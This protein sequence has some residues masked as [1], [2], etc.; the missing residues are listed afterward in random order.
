MND[1]IP[2][3]PRHL[4][5]LPKWNEYISSDIGSGLIVFL[6]ALPLCLGIALASGAPVIAGIITGIVGGT[7]TCLI[8]GSA[9]SVSG[10]A[11]GLTVIILDGIHSLGSFEKFLAAVVIAGIFQIIFAILRLGF[12]AEYIP[13]SVL[14][15]MLAGVGAVIII[16]QIPYT[17]G[18]EHVNVDNLSFSGIL[19]EGS[20]FAE[21]LSAIY[22]FNPTVTAISI[23]S[24]A[25]IYAWESII[26]RSKLMKLI[27]GALIATVVGITL[28]YIIQSFKPYGLSLSQQ[29]LVSIPIFSSLNSLVTSLTMPDFQVLFNHEVIYLGLVM[30]LVAS[31]ETLLSVEAIDRIDPYHRISPT[32]RELLAQGTGNV[33]SGMLGGLPMTAV[34]L[35]SSANVYSGGKTRLA[36]IV[37]GLLLLASLL[38]FSSLLNMIPLSTLAVILILV[39]YKLTQ[40]KE[41]KK[42]YSSGYDQFVPFLVTFIGV[43]ATDLLTGVIMGLIVGLAYVMRTNHH[44]SMTLVSEN[45]NFYLRFNKDVSF[46]NKAELKSNLCCIPD[47]ANVF[48]DGSKSLFI[49]KDIVDLI[50]DFTIQASHRGIELKLK[51]CEHKSLSTKPPTKKSIS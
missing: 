20:S 23:I 14:K 36:C 18:N 34:I 49:D 5:H 46:L 22:Y 29:H 6:V 19:P 43:I 21:V 17:L 13:G 50:N 33:I 48:I 2:T 26:P 7:I 38:C 12:I 4:K 39:G 30:A 28:S 25:L 3:S 16:K 51:H 35:R 45:N 9:L 11:A 37:H 8:S 32:N 31:I 27:P 41:F 44:D 47:N 10:P 42:M 15:G 1:N 40:I 24:L